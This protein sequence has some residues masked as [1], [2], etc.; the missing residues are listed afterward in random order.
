VCSRRTV[1]T[2]SQTFTPST[3]LFN[4]LPSKVKHRSLFLGQ[5]S[6]LAH[7]WIQDALCKHF[8][9][10]KLSELRTPA[11]VLDRSKVRDNSNTMG[12]RIASLGPDVR[13]R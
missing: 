7:S 2:P 13:F 11:L 8:V 9:G 12:E 10:K 3:D 5:N 6:N 1:T 4:L